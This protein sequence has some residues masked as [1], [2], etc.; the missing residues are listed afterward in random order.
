M[1]AEYYAG[2]WNDHDIVLVTN[3]ATDGKVKNAPSQRI[4]AQLKGRAAAARDHAEKGP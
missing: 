3:A 4:L 2:K 1:S